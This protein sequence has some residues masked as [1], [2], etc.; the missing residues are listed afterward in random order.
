ML[1]AECL[2]KMQT[3]NN[4]LELDPTTL[5]ALRHIVYSEFDKIYAF[6][7]PDSHKKYLSVVTERFLTRQTD[8]RFKTLEFFHSIETQI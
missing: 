1:C 8:H 5:A 3:S 2:R 4:A 7:I 6:S